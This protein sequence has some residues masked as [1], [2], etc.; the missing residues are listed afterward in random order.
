[1]DG[2]DGK[3]DYQ[4]A[5]YIFYYNVFSKN[6]WFMWILSSNN[7]FKNAII[8]FKVGQLVKFQERF[9]KNIKA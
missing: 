1:M 9:G 5:I 7:A 6:K 8:S 4:E 3:Q 2:L